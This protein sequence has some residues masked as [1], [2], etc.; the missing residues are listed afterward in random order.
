MISSQQMA[1]ISE[2]LDSVG[3]E[4]LELPESRI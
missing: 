4:S 2:I 3:L 1:I